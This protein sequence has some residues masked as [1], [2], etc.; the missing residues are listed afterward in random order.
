MV[1]WKNSALFVL[2]WMETNAV[3][4]SETS[5]LFTAPHGVTFQK[6]LV[7]NYITR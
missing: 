3:R 2:E 7:L 4:P 6:T 1:V 5:K